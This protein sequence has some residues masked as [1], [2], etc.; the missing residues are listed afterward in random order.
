MAV[1]TVNLS[2]LDERSRSLEGY[3]KKYNEA[4]NMMISTSQKLQNHWEGSAKT[5]FMDK[6]KSEEQALRNFSNV[7]GKY[8]KRL[9]KIKSSYD[10][11]ETK[12]RKRF[13]NLHF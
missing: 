8:Q 1:F 13:D 4:V 3:I 6:F 5:E 9:D 2:T 12:I 7:I 11:T 10:D